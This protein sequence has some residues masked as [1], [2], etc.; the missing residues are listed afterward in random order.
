VAAVPTTPADEA[1][2]TSSRKAPLPATSTGVPLAGLVLLG[3]TMV[4][5][6]VRLHRA[7]ER[8]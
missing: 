3:L 8:V 2:A 5:R 7:R 4:V 1:G 6:T